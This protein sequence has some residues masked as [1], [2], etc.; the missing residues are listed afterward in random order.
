MEHNYRISHRIGD[1]SF[2]IE[3]TDKE[4]F[5]KK[6]IEYL[7]KL[8]E[9]PAK[10]QKGFDNELSFVEKKE[11]FP[12]N[13]T[14]NE[15]YRQ[16]LKSS[17]VTSRPEMAVFFVYYL[18]KIS[19]KDSIKTSDVLE[20]FAEISYPNYNKIN[21]TDILSKA[22]RKALLNNVN[23]QWSLTITGEDYVLNFITNPEK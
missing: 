11:S 6:E 9:Q 7:S 20:C 5:D 21:M 12:P 2:E 14:I 3:S 18:S 13:L 19:K 10:H 17:K 16:I 4:W 8:S 22:K 1:S 23:N 15:F